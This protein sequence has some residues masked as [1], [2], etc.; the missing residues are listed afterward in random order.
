M[1]DFNQ[2]LDR[3]SLW[4]G[5][6]DTTSAYF[7]PEMHFGF[8]IA[9]QLIGSF[10]IWGVGYLGVSW[11]KWAGCYLGCEEVAWYLGNSFSRGRTG[12][13]WGKKS[14]NL[15]VI[16]VEGIECMLRTVD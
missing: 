3:E 12:E 2:S 8:L 7:V 11:H 4:E 6:S 15:E 1:A 10:A 13:A 5:T 14:A 9:N 16:Q